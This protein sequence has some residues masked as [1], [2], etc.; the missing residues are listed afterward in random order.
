MWLTHG[1]LFHSDLDSPRG[2]CTAYQDTDK[3]ASSLLCQNYDVLFD[4]DI[5]RSGDAE[6]VVL[7]DLVF[8]RKIGAVSIWPL[9]NSSYAHVCMSL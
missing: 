5:R 6:G 1:R 8:V 9:V 3:T 2:T 4:Q 7:W